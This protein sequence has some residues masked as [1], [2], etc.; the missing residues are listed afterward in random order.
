MSKKNKK[1]VSQTM[2]IASNING[3]YT[4][5]RKTVMVI[6]KEEYDLLKSNH[7]EREHF[8]DHKYIIISIDSGFT[9]EQI[10][11]YKDRIVKY[12]NPNKIKL[13]EGKD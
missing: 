2:L 9:S 11:D 7:R 10:K 5:G 4:I 3:K 1:E 8:S 12:N 6:E 13:D